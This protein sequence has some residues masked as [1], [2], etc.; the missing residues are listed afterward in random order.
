MNFS[1]G[2]DYYINDAKRAT[3]S[4][5]LGTENQTKIS[6]STDDEKVSQ[7]KFYLSAN[8]YIMEKFLHTSHMPCT[9]STETSSLASLSNKQSPFSYNTRSLPRMNQTSPRPASVDLGYITKASSNAD[10]DNDIPANIIAQFEQEMLH[11][12]F[13]RDSFRAR[14]VSTRQFVLN[15]IFDESF[16]IS[17]NTENVSKNETNKTHS[18]NLSMNR[19]GPNVMVETIFTDLPTLRRSASQKNDKTRPL[20]YRSGSGR[21]NISN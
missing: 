16:C 13:K 17:T 8:S 10:S 19:D 4:R 1:Y 5:K 11:N 21:S 2:R 20:V 9:S 14:N 7:Q 12:N 18:K 15:P 3:G 6:H